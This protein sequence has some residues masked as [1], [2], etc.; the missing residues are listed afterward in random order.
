MRSQNGCWVY[1]FGECC[2][3]EFKYPYPQK[4][5][6]PIYMNIPAWTFAGGGI[7]YCGSHLIHFHDFIAKVVDDFDGDLAGFRF[8]EGVT[9][10][11]VLGITGFFVDFGF[12]GTFEF[13]KGLIRSGEVGVADE[14]TLFVV[15]GIDEPAGDLIRSVAAD[16]SG[17]GVVDIETFDFNLIFDVF[18]LVELNIRLSEGNEQVAGT[19]LFEQIFI[20]WNIVVHADGQHL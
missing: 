4:F 2:S 16:F 7:W 11:G 20:H 19:G 8:V 3:S 18:A 5:L 17:G 1:G 14:E 13:V 10:G 15:I 6:K 12:E 9:F